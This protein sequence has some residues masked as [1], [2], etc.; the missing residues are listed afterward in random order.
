MELELFDVLDCAGRRTGTVIDR[1]AAHATGAWHGAFHC[2]MAYPAAGE[3]RVLFQKRAAVKKIAPGLFD[4]TVGGHY[5][6]GED[7]AAAGPR[8]IAEELGLAVPFADLVPLGRRVF[9]LCPAPGIREQEIQDVFLL[10][11]PGRPER[12]RLQPDEVDGMLELDVEAGIALFDSGGPASGTFIDRSGT[13]SPLTVRQEDFVPCLD[14]YYLK[15]LL[16]A[17]RYLRGER[18]A[19]AV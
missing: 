10:P 12:M 17:R 7:A 4:V 8:E 11:R 18:S 5:A 9:L 1:D 14:R 13:T 15:M 6:S 2:L 19:L 16:L 3:H